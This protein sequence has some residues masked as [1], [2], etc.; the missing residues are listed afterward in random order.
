MT[1]AEKTRFYAQVETAAVAKVGTPL[2]GILGS[3]ASLSVAGKFSGTAEG[4]SADT[5]SASYK[6]AEKFTESVQFAELTSTIGQGARDLAATFQLS[7]TDSA[8]T[9]LT[10]SSATL[11][12]AKVVSDVAAGLRSKGVRWCSDKSAEL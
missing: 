2:G 7:G 10:S 4:T 11:E 5:Q 3:E 8:V 6:E 1:D 9:N 12:A